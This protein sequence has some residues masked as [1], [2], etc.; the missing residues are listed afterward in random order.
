MCWLGLGMTGGVRPRLGVAV[1]CVVA[2]HGLARPRF[3]LIWS[4]LGLTG[5]DDG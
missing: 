5:E 1:L 2:A 4:G 3:G